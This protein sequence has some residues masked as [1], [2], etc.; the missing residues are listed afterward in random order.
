MYAK[1]QQIIAATLTLTPSFGVVD[2]QILF[3]GN[4]DFSASHASFDISPD[5]KEFLLPRSQSADARMI[6]VY[7]WRAELAATVRS[8]QR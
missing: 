7:D 8:G 5:G 1:G 3:D 2:R 6:V 4:F